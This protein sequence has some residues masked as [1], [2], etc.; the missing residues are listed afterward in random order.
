MNGPLPVGDIVAVVI[1]IGAAIVIAYYWDDIKAK[2]MFIYKFGDDDKEEI[3]NTMDD[4]NAFK[5]T[6]RSIG[7]RYLTVIYDT[8]RSVIFL[9]HVR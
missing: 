4:Y 5:Y 9:A 7:G 3:L 2:W 6:W 8:E 1:D